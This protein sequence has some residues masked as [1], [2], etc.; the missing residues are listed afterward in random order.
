MFKNKLAAKVVFFGNV[1]PFLNVTFFRLDFSKK[2]SKR[3]SQKG[4][5]FM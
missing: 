5:N 2:N 3:Y 1:T 4:N